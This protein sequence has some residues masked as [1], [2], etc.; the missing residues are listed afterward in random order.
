[1]AYRNINSGA[2]S[3]KKNREE[4]SGRARGAA[5][6]A[7]IVAATSAGKTQQHG[8]ERETSN[9]GEGGMADKGDINSANKGGEEET[10][11][12]KSGERHSEIAY[13]EN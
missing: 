11:A 1:M 5:A 9:A 13:G 12:N 7:K 3:K 10:K 2:G 6:L 8:T 4:G